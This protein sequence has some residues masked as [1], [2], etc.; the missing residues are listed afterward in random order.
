[1]SNQEERLTE[2]LFSSIDEL[3]RE[4]GKSQQL[5]K[6]LS[7]VLFGENGGLDSLA[8]VSLQ[9][10]LEEKLGEAFDTDLTLDFDQ[11]A[12]TAGTTSR[13]VGDLLKD[14]LPL[15]RGARTA[16]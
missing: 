13:T 7:T 14:L 16:P 5:E 10:I 11:I 4:L 15:I 3:N 1:M 8:V 9:M 2:I 12:E 6:S